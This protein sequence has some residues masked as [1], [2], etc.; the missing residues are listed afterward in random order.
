MN[1][2]YIPLSPASTTKNAQEKKLENFGK[3]QRPFPAES[4]VLGSRFEGVN[5]WCAAV[6]AAAR[7]IGR[8]GAE[9]R[10]LFN[11]APRQKTPNE[12]RT[13]TLKILFDTSDPPPAAY[14]HH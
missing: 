10:G 1:S 5:G 13:K 11:K 12:T 6:A 9:F 4:G 3:N 8:A 2:S 7:W 14:A